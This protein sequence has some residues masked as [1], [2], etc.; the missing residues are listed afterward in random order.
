MNVIRTVKRQMIGRM[1]DAH[2]NILNLLKIIELAGD[3]NYLE[4]GVLH[5]GSLC[6]VGL[7]KQKLNQAG[8]CIGIDPLD[9]YYSDYIDAAHPTQIGC[10]VDP[11]TRVPVTI[12]TVQENIKRFDL[13]NRCQIIQ[14]KSY[15][16]PDEARAHKYAVCYIDGDHWGEEPYQDFLSVKDLVTGFIVFDNHT[17]R[18]DGVMKACKLAEQDPDWKKFLE[19]EGIFILERR[20]DETGQ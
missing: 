13:L 6:A 16:F 12:E 15:P 17:P 2:D 20:C 10:E 19:V 18:N 4:I 9:G 7:L 5:G 3:G 14:A 11:R 8:M 1:C